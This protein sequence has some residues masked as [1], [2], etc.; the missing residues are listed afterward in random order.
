M[1]K[2]TV[3]GETAAER[4][5]FLKDLLLTGVYQITFTKVNGESRTM[6]CTLQP[7]LLPKPIVEG[8]K[9]DIPEEERNPDNMAVWVTDANGWRSFKLMN[10]T[11]VETL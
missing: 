7:D 8:I 4:R 2:I 10:V 3:V 9:K 6:P 1:S 5:V 11:K